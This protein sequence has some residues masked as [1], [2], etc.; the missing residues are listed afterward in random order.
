MAATFTDQLK[1]LYKQEWQRE[2]NRSANLVRNNRHARIEAKFSNT[3]HHT[4]PP[5]TSPSQS[6]LKAVAF[7]TGAVVV[8]RT[9]GDA[10]IA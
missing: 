4:M 3:I 2:P 5:S 1:A 10:F 7:F 6:L 9:W 8:V